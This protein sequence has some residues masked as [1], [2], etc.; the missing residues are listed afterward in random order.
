MPQPEPV[1]L[2]FITG[3]ARSGKSQLAEKMASESRR[4]V[5]YLATM[6][7]IAQ[8]QE[9]DE[10]IDRH[11]RRRPA[12]WQTVEEPLMPERVIGGIEPGRLVL[13]DC[14]SLYVSNLLLSMP[15]AMENSQVRRELEENVLKEV[16]SFLAALEARRDLSY[17]LVS[18]EVGSSIVPDN[19]LARTYR[20]LLGMANQKAAAAAGQVYLCVS[21]LSLK[22]KPQ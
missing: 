17:I 14:L 12:S 22:L 19:H 1:D 2:I 15:Y 16:D 20:D 11:C 4:P 10:R 7:R 18:N 5:V 9:L 6:A 13:I 3:G 8:D 21:G